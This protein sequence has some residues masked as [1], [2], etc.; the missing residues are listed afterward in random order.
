MKFLNYLLVITLSS[1]LFACSGNT[2]TIKASNVYIESDASQYFKVE[3]GDY[4]LEKKDGILYM[5][6]TFKKVKDPYDYSASNPKG[7]DGT[8]KGKISFHQPFD[9]IT[10]TSTGTEVGY[11]M[12][13]K[14]DYLEDLLYKNRIGA[15]VS[16][17]FSGKFDS[18]SL[19]GYNNKDNID[20][21][22]AF[23]QIEDFKVEAHAWVHRI[24]D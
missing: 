4:T 12:S 2:K 18:T 14:D 3:D 10:L 6:V 16:V 11:R 13:A 9:I 22:K 23:E 20:V 24:E 17:L 5:K 15:T 8:R 21:D 1:T 7:H 19:V